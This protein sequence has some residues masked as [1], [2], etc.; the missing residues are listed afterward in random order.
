[1][2]DGDFENLGDNEI[3]LINDGEGVAL[4]GKSSV[5]EAYLRALDLPSRDL[6]FT[7]GRKEMSYAGA[8]LT[9]GLNIKENAGRWV[10]LTEES[11]KAMKVGKLMKGSSPS[12]SRAVVVNSSGNSIKSLLE[13]VNTP[14][15][16]IRN[17]AALSSLAGM[18]T[19]IAMQQQMDEISD[20]LSTIDQ[21]I[22]S[23]LRA[24]KDTV[25]ADMIGVEL[26]VDDA[27]VVREQVGGVSPVT[28]SK[29]QST[30]TTVARTQAYALLQ[31][32]A[33][34]G[35]LENSTKLNDMARASKEAESSV[36]EWLVV[37]ARSF[38]VQ[39]ATSVLE[40]DRVLEES[41]EQIEQH[42]QGL[43]NA[44]E[45]RLEK[46]TKT[47]NALLKRIEE[48][49]GSANS[50]VL[51]HPS[52]AKAVAVSGAGMAVEILDFHG[53][54]GADDNSTA[55]SVKNWT[56]ALLEVRDK[57]IES[58]VDGFDAA[59][60]ISKLTLK[61]SKAASERLTNKIAAR[62]RRMSSSDSRDD[63]GKED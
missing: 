19:Q 31:L 27:M 11:A 35:S 25:L 1:M 34:A 28:W 46:I 38:H 55:V 22:D 60:R 49:T 59:G 63:G 39:D 33:I 52:T 54:I 41:P 43:V 53:K 29:I 16:F 44:R 23:I 6:D 26:I 58:G 37:L 10:K 17:P 57:A 45:N 7:R 36:Q 56:A 51:L 15:S 3:E 50:K 12:V 61:R 13:I 62:A 2:E 47:T 20:Y 9:A 30:A 24:Q 5:V 4:I 48:T 40:L 14:A 32:D 8:A 42:R 18:M 21:K